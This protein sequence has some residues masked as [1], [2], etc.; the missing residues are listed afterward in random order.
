MRT[1]RGKI[2]KSSWPKIIVRKWLNIQSRGDEF[3]SDSNSYC[4]KVLANR[5]NREEEELLRPRLLR[6]RTGEIIRNYWENE[7]IPPLILVRSP[8]LIPFRW[9]PSATW[10]VDDTDS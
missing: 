10:T 2:S 4:F 1:E 5:K 8:N 7:L 3:Y 9:G 6:R